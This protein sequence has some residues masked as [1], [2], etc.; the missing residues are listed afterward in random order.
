[1]STTYI[2]E[3]GKNAKKR[4]FLAMRCTLWTKFLTAAKNYS[5][6]ATAA[7]TTAAIRLAN[8]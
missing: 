1:M 2:A 7:N 5:N 6:P 4:S 3:F 8:S